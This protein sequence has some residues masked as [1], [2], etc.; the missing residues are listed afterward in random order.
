MTMNKIIIQA[1][2]QFFGRNFWVVLCG[3]AATFG[4]AVAVFQTVGQQVALIMIGLTVFAISLWDLKWGV[5][6]VF[7]ELFANSHGRL[8]SGEFYGFDVSLRMVV[9]VA[10]MIAWLVL[11]IMKR[12]QPKWND[13]RLAAFVPLGLA[14]I[15]GLIVG[16]AGDQPIINV[17][18]DGNGYFYLAYLGPIVSITWNQENRRLLL[19]TLTASAT[20]VGGL[21]YGLVYI[22]AHFPEHALDGVYQFVRDTRTAEVTRMQE[23]VYRVF[24]QAQ[25]SVM[26]ALLILFG[27]YWF[28]QSKWSD[29]KTFIPYLSF[30][31]GVIII[32][33]SRSFWVGAAASAVVFLALYYKHSN[34]SVSVVKNIGW[35][36]LV[37][38]GA[39]LLILAVISFPIPSGS[40]S[41]GSYSDTVSK[42]AS[43]SQDVAVASRWNLL[44]P[45]WGQIADRPVSGHGFGKVIAYDSDD[46]RAE[47]QGSETVWET[48][49]F[50]WG[51]LD[52]WLKMGLA[53]LLGFGW[54][55]FVLAKDLY[56]QIASARGW[57]H[58][59]LLSSIVLVYVTH[60]FSPYLNHP[61][62]L[63]VL[64][65]VVP[66]VSR[67]NLTNV[68]PGPVTG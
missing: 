52:V 22:F 61:L 10:V 25:L 41:L 33:M 34:M 9:F 42:R 37:K 23:G 44:D 54:V 8:I 60:I 38:F 40:G 21:T 11:V 18:N 59:G 64:L 15:L 2:K 56:K 35:T 36:I 65:F 28:L 67:S 1:K 57:L 62:G 55:F 27:C 31:T 5:V 58:V 19:Q 12:A 45:M 30:L 6:I 49:S 66:F 17:F 47:A 29:R 50:E 13:R 14:V 16:V 53:G 7:A 46:P 24:L 39:L 32:S 63:G 43:Q 68:K 26:V 3:L 51:W 4:L 20:W 48:Y